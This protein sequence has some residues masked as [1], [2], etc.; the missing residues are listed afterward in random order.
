MKLRVFGMVKVR[1]DWARYDG[2][3]VKLYTEDDRLVGEIYSGASFCLPEPPY[4]AEKS[5]CAEC[6]K[7]VRLNK[8]LLGSLHICSDKS[9]GISD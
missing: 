5:R 3:T 6:G 4:E 8:F 7:L 1:A 2:D 9:Y